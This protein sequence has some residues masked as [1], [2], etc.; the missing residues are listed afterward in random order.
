M[1]TVTTKELQIARQLEAAFELYVKDLSPLVAY[2]LRNGAGKRGTNKKYEW[3]ERSF[4]RIEAEVNAAFDSSTYSSTPID[5]V[6]TDTSNI[7]AK[8]IL[9]FETAAGVSAGNIKVYVTSVTNATTIK[10][11]KI[12]WND[13][14][15]A[16]GA[17]AILGNNAHEENSKKGTPRAIQMPVTKYN[18]FQI[19]DTLLEN[20]RTVEGSNV[21][22]DIGKLAD[23]RSNGFYYIQ[24]QLTE[25]LANGLR[26]K[27]NTPDGKEIY[28][29]GGLA[30]FVVNTLTKTGQDMAKA[31]LDEAVEVIV[32][33]GGK[34]NAVRCNTKQAIKLSNMDESKIQINLNEQV[35]GNVVTALQAGIPVEG[36]RIDLIIVDTTMPEDEIDIFDINNIA[37]VPYSN[38]GIRE[39]D[40][41]ENGQDGQTL[42]M[43][44]EYT[45][46]HRN[47]G[48][49]A[50]KITGL[51]V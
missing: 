2:A 4:K 24:R 40:A 16:A 5:L 9:R 23:L 18:Y 37:L 30:E 35:R 47:A 44:G 15:L 31:I 14:N 50:V 41:T 17:K 38:G 6:L 12:G 51:N 45:V 43:L 8:D 46:E 39:M 32:K 22:A 27:F 26:A 19:F 33:G 28:T 1:S 11:M 42:R 34:A 36:S 13:V 49:T 48:E 21:Y 3:F 29:A 25:M 7:R 20:S 10:V